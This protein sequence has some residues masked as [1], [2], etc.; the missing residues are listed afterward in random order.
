VVGV[1]FLD[2]RLGCLSANLP[3][4]SRSAKI[5][6]AAFASLDCVMKTEL[7][8]PWWQFFQTPTFKK[9]CEAQD[10]LYS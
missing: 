10:Y 1:V 8:F 7:S 2:N 6:D 3:P 9:L 4:E 5:I